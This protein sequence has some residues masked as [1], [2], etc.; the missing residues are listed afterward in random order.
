MKN[1]LRKHCRQDKKGEV[2]RK[3]ERVLRIA[4]L[5]MKDTDLEPDCP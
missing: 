3:R 2:Q 1:I 4:E 5:R